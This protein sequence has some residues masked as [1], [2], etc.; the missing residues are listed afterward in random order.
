MNLFKIFSL[1]SFFTLSLLAAQTACQDIYFE[2]EAPNII[3]TKLTVR[4]KELCYREFAV[5][6][7]GVSR[8]PLWSA[9]H[10]K[11]E[12]LNTYTVRSGEFYPEERL[13]FDDRAEL[14][15]YSHSGYDRGHMSPSG[16]FTDP[17][18]NKEC[19]SLANMIPGT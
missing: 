8:T 14:E 4:T 17:L 9:E 6:Y 7:S 12:R 13:P 18:S 10:L 1:V 3:N 2:Y 16:D 5:M 11:R 15:D 19:F